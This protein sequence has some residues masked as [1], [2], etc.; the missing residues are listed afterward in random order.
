M[1]EQFMHFRNLV[2]LHRWQAERL[3]P[4]P[5]L[6]YRQYGM[7]R[8]LSWEDYR[9]AALAC[10]AALIES[11][12]APGDRVGLWSENR[13]EWLLADIGIMT[14]GA[15]NVPAHV[16][17]PAP[18]VARQMADAGVR[19]LFVSNV[20]QLDRIRAVQG[21][22]PELKGVTVFDRAKGIDASTWGGFLQRGRMRLAKLTKEL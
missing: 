21:E 17:Y 4:R 16:S 2:E 7:F 9:H 12:I 11:G 19:W 1:Q 15:V 20:D 10:A 3:G 14:A 18:A 5:A 6:R 13:M 22:M 8:N